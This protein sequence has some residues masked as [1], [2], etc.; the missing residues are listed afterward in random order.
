MSRKTS[1]LKNTGIFA[2]GNLG[3]KLLMFLIIPFFT[4]YIAPEGMGRYDVLYVIIQLLQTV[5]VLAIPESLFDGFS[6]F[7]PVKIEKE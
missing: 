1:L 7:H 3:S 6:I 2:V 5:V 4:Y